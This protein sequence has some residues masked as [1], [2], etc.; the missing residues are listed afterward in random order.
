MPNNTQG[1]SP[2][3]EHHYTRGDDTP[4]S[5]EEREEIDKTWRAYTPFQTDTH[6]LDGPPKRRGL[7]F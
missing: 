5:E 7:T 1:K 4:M 3:E 6:N 2:F